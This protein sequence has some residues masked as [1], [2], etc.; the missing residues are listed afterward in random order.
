MIRLCAQTCTRNCYALQNSGLYSL[1]LNCQQRKS[2]KID[3]RSFGDAAKFQGG[4]GKINGPQRLWWSE[5]DSVA[6]LISWGGGGGGEGG[7]SI[8]LQM[9]TKHNMIRIFS[10]PACITSLQRS[11]QIAMQL[12]R[13][14]DV[15]C[16]S[17]HPEGFLRKS[18]FL[19]E[20]SRW[21]KTHLPSLR[22]QFH[23]HFNYM[24]IQPD[25]NFVS[26]ERLVFAVIVKLLRIW[27]I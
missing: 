18:T 25:F 22:L 19:M 20:M 4:P 23:H 9:A 5:V 8:G 26:C 6:S 17:D 24:S 21:W 13:C 10:T 27:L 7:I 14:W 1:P 2:W 12:G 16:A 11:G 3:V 15:W